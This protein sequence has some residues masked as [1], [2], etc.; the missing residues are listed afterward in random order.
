MKVYPGNRTF[1]MCAK[2]QYSSIHFE[3]IKTICQYRYYGK[4][5]LLLCISIFHVLCS[6]MGKHLFRF[7]FKCLN[8]M[9]KGIMKIIAGVSSKVHTA[10]L[11]VNFQILRLHQLVG[12]YIGLSVYKIFNKDIHKILNDY[13]L[14]NYEI[15]DHNTR[16]IGQYPSWCYQNQQTRYY[17]A[18][19]MC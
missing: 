4:P 5:V 16:P 15:Y 8:I 11:F 17:H 18:I 12:C 3:E 2:N 10:P 13:F 7:N 19:L 9:L 6:C 1:T 14:P